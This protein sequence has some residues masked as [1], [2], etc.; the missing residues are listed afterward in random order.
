[1]TT[2]LV[3]DVNYGLTY[4]IEENGKSYR[5]DT[6]IYVT[7]GGFKGLVEF[8]KVYY[9]LEGVLTNGMLKFSTLNLTLIY[10]KN[11]YWSNKTDGTQICN[12]KTLDELDYCI[13]RW[14][15]A[16]YKT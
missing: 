15:Y 10:N 6:G 14:L 12:E 3:K 16:T 1:M 2:N 11:P 9:Q 13:Y 7:D 5:N 8:L 4:R